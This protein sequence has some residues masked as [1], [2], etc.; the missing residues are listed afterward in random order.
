M[1]SCRKL[2][3]HGPTAHRFQSSDHSRSISNCS[4]ERW[5]DRRLRPSMIEDDDSIKCTTGKQ[6]CGKYACRWR[7]RW[8]QS[9]DDSQ[10]LIVLQNDESIESYDFCI[11]DREY[12]DDNI[13]RMT[14]KKKKRWG[15]YACR[16]R[17]RW[18]ESNNDSQFL[19]VLQKDRLIEDYDL[20]IN[21]RRWQY[22]MITDKQKCGKYICRWRRKESND[23]SHS[24]FV[25]QNDGSIEGYDF[26]INDRE[27]ND[28]NIKRMTDKKKKRCGKYAYQWRRREVMTLTR[29]LIILQKDRLI[30]GYDFRINDRRWQQYKMI[31]DEKD[32]ENTLV[33][34]DEENSM[35][36][37][38]RFLFSRTIDR[39]KILTFNDR[40]WWQY[41]IYDG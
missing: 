2:C 26:C 1:K 41:K 33:D 18:R 4:P 27:Y 3:Y 8:R 28:D 16:W 10:F 24:I 7:W 17:R 38:I 15:K 11:N 5:I 36:I 20:H 40:G 12:N 34:E 6:K 19:I 32:M 37:L 35:T 39:S 14:D 13:K 21:D 31:T 29:F 25:L 9:S 22:K 23:N 30:E